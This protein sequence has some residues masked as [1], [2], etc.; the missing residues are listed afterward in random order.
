MAACV[1][2][3]FLVQEEILGVGSFRLLDAACGPWVE[4]FRFHD[5]R[6]RENIV[7]A[8]R[9]LPR[10]LQLYVGHQLIFGPQPRHIT[11]SPTL[12]QLTEIRI[13]NF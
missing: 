1:L 9:A 11:L 12:S 8:A 5:W 7:V 3:W 6:L 2:K 10:S 13:L 4:N